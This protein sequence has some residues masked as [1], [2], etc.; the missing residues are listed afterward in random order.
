MLYSMPHRRHVT[1]VTATLT[2]VVYFTPLIRPVVADACHDI[3]HLAE[4]WRDRRSLAVEHHHDHDESNSAGRR[5]HVHPEGGE[6]HSHARLVDLL[7]LANASGQDELTEDEAASSSEVRLA[8]H[9]P[10]APGSPTLSHR[11]TQ[12]GVRGSAHLVSEVPYS[13]PVPPPRV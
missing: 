6:A 11:R 4:S 1:T 12:D 7:L 2:M 8:A 9:L 3:Y 5:T 10:A 13:P